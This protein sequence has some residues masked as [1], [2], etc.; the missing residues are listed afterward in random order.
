MKLRILFAILA[1][2]A[3]AQ[4]RTSASYTIATDTLAAAGASSASALYSNTASVG[5]ITGT[6]SSAARVA[7]AGFTG[8][9]YEPTGLTL[10]AGILSLA[11]NST[12]QLQP[13]L[14]LDDA[15]FVAVPPAL[16]VWS[17]LDGPASVSP[18]G[19]ASGATVF[20]N[21]TA[22]FRVAH[23]SYIA[24]LTLPVLNVNTDDFGLYAADGIADDWQVQFFG[25]ENPLAAPT[26]DPDGDG[27][28]N[29]FEF[30]AGIVPTD[31]A[32]RFRLRIE[33]VPGQPAQRRI[34]FSPRLAG[35]SYVVKSRVSLTLGTWENL[36]TTATSDAAEER[37]ITDLDATTPAKFYRVEIAT[38]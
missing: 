25:E 14:A 31:P 20:T 13:L 23:L 24:E 18:A 21:D 37:T 34:V 2:P 38:P 30:T 15:T 4:E 5:E 36:T 27:Q 8:Q 35:R 22:T 12:R 6:K 32:S 3:F 29:L 11:E 33:P 1:V 9:L 17:V 7:K 10:T 19:L 16:G 28:T 26:L